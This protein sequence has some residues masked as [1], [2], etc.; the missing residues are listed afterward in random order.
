MQK[1]ENQ[2]CVILGGGGHARVLID[3]LKT[4]AAAVPYAVLDADHSLW[5][6]ELLGVLIMGGDDLLYDLVKRGVNCFVV[7]L[8]SAGDNR[9]R[10]RLFELGLS[11][12]LKPITVAHP[13]A[14]CSQ[15]A[16]VGPGSQLFPGCIVNAGVTI[17]DNAIINSGAIIEH[18]CVIGNHVHVAT[19]AKLSSAVRVGSGAHVGVGASIRQCITIGER[20]IV[21]A[22]AVV[23]KDVPPYITVV[24]VPARSISERA[25]Y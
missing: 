20:A 11:H 14:I 8:G 9:P 12:H 1:I 18:D 19:G 4:G 24:G 7:G 23:V 22:G 13:T 21:G 5:G 15:W 16:T 25:K 3:G 6:R 10:E 17:G 2:I